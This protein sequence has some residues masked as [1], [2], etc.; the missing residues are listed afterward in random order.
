[1]S[2]NRLGTGIDAFMEFRKNITSG[3][4]T[5]ESTLHRNYM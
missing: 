5:R 1:M 3:N 4:Y 2:Q